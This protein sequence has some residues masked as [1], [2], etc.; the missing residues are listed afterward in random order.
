M[1]VF[2]IR[3]PLIRR[4]AKKHTDRK[5]GQ[6]GLA[7]TVNLAT[8]FGTQQDLIFQI[9]DCVPGVPRSPAIAINQ[10]STVS[11]SGK[12]CDRITGGRSKSQRLHGV[13]RAALAEAAHG[14][15]IAD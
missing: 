12:L 3:Q 1:S 6:G 15:G 11:A 10:R 8:L 4:I 2:Q 9:L 14:T 7:V 5:A 13:N